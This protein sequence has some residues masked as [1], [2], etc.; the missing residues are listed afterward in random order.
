MRWGCVRA[1]CVRGR[2]GGS[3]LSNRLRLFP[4]EMFEDLFGALGRPS[5]PASVVATVLVL[6]AL[7][8]C[9][10][11]EA[12]ERLRCD[13]RWKAAAGSGG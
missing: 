7:E 1:W 10:D 3:W 4:D 6:Q 9:C 12:A 2:C 8:G 13:L 5:Q 11:R